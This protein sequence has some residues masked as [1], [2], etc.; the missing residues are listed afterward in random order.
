[1]TDRE[2]LLSRWRENG[3]GILPLVFPF[4]A[5]AYR[6]GLFAP[7]KLH[8]YGISVSQSV[9]RDPN[10][11]RESVLAG[12]GEDFMRIHHISVISVLAVVIFVNDIVIDIVILSA[13]L[14]CYGNET[15]R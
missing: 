2:N 15:D 13:G 1:V 4:T 10:L 6:R 3:I 5:A 9:G 11:F 8:F 12:L 14:S 7:V